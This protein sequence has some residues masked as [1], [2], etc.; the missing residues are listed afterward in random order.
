MAEYITRN[1]G[2]ESFE[3]I[4]KTED[5]KQYEEME[6]FCRQLI[7]HLKP[8]EPRYKLKRY[9]RPKCPNS[10]HCGDCI[11]ADQHW[12]GLKFRGMSCRIDAK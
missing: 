4:F 5:K 12:E 2:G 10:Y 3:V 11:H 8:R 1:H 7:G 6:H 9:K